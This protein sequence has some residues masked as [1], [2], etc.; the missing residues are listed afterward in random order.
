MTLGS[1]RPDF[2]SQGKVYHLLVRYKSEEDIREELANYDWGQLEGL[3]LD[4]DED[5]EV[6]NAKY[7]QE[8]LLAIAGLE[9]RDPDDMEKPKSKGDVQISVEI[10]K[11]LEKGY[12]LVAGRGRKLLDDRLHVR[13]RLWK[14]MQDNTM[15]YLV[16]DCVV[17]VPADVLEGV[18]LVDAPGTGVVSPQEQK[19]L[20]DV[21]ETA[22]AVVVCMQRNLQ[23]CKHIKDAIPNCSLFQKHVESPTV[24]GCPI[25]F[26]SAADE[27]RD[28]SPLD[29]RESVSEFKESKAE[30]TRQNKQAIKNMVG[31]AMKEMKE[32]GKL[33]QTADKA[34]LDACLPGLEANIFTSKPLLWASVSMCPGEKEDAGVQVA[35]EQKNK[36]LDDVTRMLSCIRGRP[37]SERQIIKAFFEKVWRMCQCVCVCVC[38]CVCICICICVFWGTLPC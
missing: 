12:E 21:L 25:F 4:D 10:K 24:N 7:K 36:V 33:Q 19:A 16:Q 23:A 30:I 17:Y 6:A 37:A 29:K 32:K 14:L 9:G 11:K 20:Q 26:F 18:E 3:D 35:R 5:P 15:P 31:K 2:A 13:E 1:P 22:D 8:M 34:V 27:Q 28:F 38:V